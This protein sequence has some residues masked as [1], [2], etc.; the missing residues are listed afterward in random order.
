MGTVY[1]QLK[2]IYYTALMVLQPKITKGFKKA[3]SGTRN[4]TQQTYLSANKVQ[5]LEVFQHAAKG[6]KKSGET[7]IH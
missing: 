5:L 7:F 2:A 1:R 4:V 3:S 6:H